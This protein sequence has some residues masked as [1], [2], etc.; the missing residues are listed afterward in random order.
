LD[1]NDEAELASSE[2]R[3]ISIFG[4]GYVGAVSL[5]CL[6]RDG[7]E[8]TGVDIDPNKL[9]LLQ[10]GQAPIVEAGIQELTRAVMRGGTVHV[11][12]N[13]RQA[14]LTTDISFV[15]VGTPAQRNG[16]QDLSAITRI[17]TQ[18]GAA[19][20]DKD[21]RHVIVIRST[22]Q[23]GTVEEVVQPAIEE[24][25]G[26]KAGK[27]FSLCF[28]PEFLREG[29]SIRDYDNPPF[30]VIGATDDYGFEMLRTVFGE[31]PGEFIRTSIRTAEMLKYACNAFHALKITFANEIGR[32]AQPL[33]VDP[34]EVMK[35][36]CMDRQLNISSAYLR[37]GFAF[38]GSCLPK[39][40]KA[41]VHAAKSHDVE[42]PMLSNVLASNF[43]HIDMAVER[44]LASGK[45]SVG[46]IGLSFKPGTDDLRES[47]LVVMAER[48]IGKG[49]QLQVYDPQVNVA[50]LI[51]ANRRY[52]EES[53]PHI[54]SL[55]TSELDQLVGDCDV[56]VV[57]MK[58]ASVL[59][60]LERHTRAD[61]ILLDIA[62]LPDPTAQRALYQGVCW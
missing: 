47:P 33:G 24:A 18:L 8:V 35:L 30:T 21:S 27:D 38:G 32:I 34:H 62:G 54:A 48:F 56:L 23:P 16:S 60:A 28:Q 46:L 36:L 22:V 26:L 43:A 14:V 58:N 53:I 13:V 57:A 6:A 9:A 25:S 59:D 39:D 20:R 17:A 61:Q 10:S 52:I 11:T 31:L 44:V 37:P 55:M 45:R 4:L 42:V 12:E 3:R 19:L 50:R 7:H 49:L 5:A 15:C 41:L 1:A 51:G 2:R 29:T 40:L